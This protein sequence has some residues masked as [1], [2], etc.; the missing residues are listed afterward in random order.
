VLLPALRQAGFR[1]LVAATSA[2]GLSARR[3][4]EGAG[5]AR[6]VSGA[7]AVIDDPGVDVVVIATPHDTHAELVIQALRA[8]KHVFCEKPLALS[9]DELDEVEAAWAGS[10]RVL[11]V[12][13]N[14][15]WSPAVGAVR[16]HFS[17][18][19]GPLVVTYRVNAGPLP[20]THWYQD[21]RKGGRL[22]GEMCHFVDTCSAIV[23]EEPSTVSAAG[24]GFDALLLAQELAV[25]LRYPGGSLATISYASGGHP[26]TEKERCEVL[27][28]RRSATILDFREVTLDG[29]RVSKGVAGKGHDQEAVAFRRAV[30][31]GDMAS[32]RSFI[33]VS[34]TM[35]E[36]AASLGSS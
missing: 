11:F 16:A 25:L 28:R 7:G 15:R 4:G 30:M 31:N 5:F 36:A 21:R 1:R 12:G 14:R 9:S 2:S 17:D 23:G 20:A 35:L 34:R 27:G 32:S 24:S 22:L 10:G 18:G 33:A 29:R 13:F 8:E 19:T 6:V 26:G 3:L